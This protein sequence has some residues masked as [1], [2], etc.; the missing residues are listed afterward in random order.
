MSQM[1]F[2]CPKLWKYVNH[3]RR[4]I[5][6]GREMMSVDIW[7]SFLFVSNLQ[8]YNSIN[9]YRKNMHSCEFGVITPQRYFLRKDNVNVLLSG[10]K[11]WLILY[12]AQ[13]V[14]S[15]DQWLIVKVLMLTWARTPKRKSCYFTKNLKAREKAMS[16]QPP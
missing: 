14:W 12:N 13:G 5:I 16:S 7:N 3:Q 4:I 9:W 2:S 1:N 6:W 15:L 8:I 11:C 10:L